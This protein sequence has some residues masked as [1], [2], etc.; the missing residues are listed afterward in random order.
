MKLLVLFLIIYPIYVGV[1]LLNIKYVCTVCLI[2]IQFH[3]L[4][5][6]T[7]ISRG[8]QVDLI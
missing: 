1:Y 8:V 7:L 4:I 6:P 3:S 2:I 5:I